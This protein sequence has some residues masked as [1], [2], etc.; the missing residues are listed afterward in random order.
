M[1]YDIP[2]FSDEDYTIEKDTE[3]YKKSQNQ[4]L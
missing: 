4:N 3:E 1:K 2:P